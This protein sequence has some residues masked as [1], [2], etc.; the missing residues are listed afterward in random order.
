MIECKCKRKIRN[1]YTAAMNECTCSSNELLYMQQ[2]WN[3]PRVLFQ[4][5][6]FLKEF[7]IDCSHIQIHVYIIFISSQTSYL[8][9]LLR[10]HLGLHAARQTSW[11]PVTGSA[12]SGRFS[13]S[14]NLVYFDPAYPALP[15]GTLPD[16]ILVYLLVPYLTLLSTTPYPILY[17]PFLPYLACLIAPS[18]LLRSYHTRSLPADY[19]I[20]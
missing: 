16:S 1:I 11:W 4:V 13:P 7:Q 2:K 15:S 17:V 19:K 14:S 3:A 20:L 10:L 9:L 12:S 6:E 8:F 5:K 18:P